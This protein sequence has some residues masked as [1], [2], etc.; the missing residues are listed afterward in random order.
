[1]LQAIMDGKLDR[2]TL[3]PEFNKVI[4]PELEYGAQQQISAMGKIKSFQVVSSDVKGGVTTRVYLVKIGDAEL[5]VSVTVN[6]KGL[7]A[8]FGIQG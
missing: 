6:A 1:M 5:H 3:T 8:G 2:T 7:I 4:T